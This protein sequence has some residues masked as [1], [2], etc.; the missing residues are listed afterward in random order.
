MES[1]DGS[2]TWARMVEAAAS[3]RRLRNFIAENHFYEG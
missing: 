3:R 1:Q 2:S